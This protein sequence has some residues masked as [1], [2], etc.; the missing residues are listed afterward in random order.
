MGNNIF[1][2]LSDQIDIL[3]DSSSRMESSED[4]LSP[5]ISRRL[6]FVLFEEIVEDSPIQSREFIFD[7][8]VCSEDKEL[9]DSISSHGITTPIIIRERPDGKRSRDI[10][11]GQNPGERKFALVAGHRRVAAGKAAGLSGA[12]GVILNPGDDPDLITLAEN[13]GRK[14]LSTYEKG[15]ALR[16]LQERQGLSGRQVSEAVGLSRTHTNRLLNA[17]EAPEPLQKL[18]KEGRLSATALVNL[19]DHWTEISDHISEENSGD[20]QSLSQNEI[21]DLSDQLS[22]GASI[23]QALDIISAIKGNPRPPQAVSHP[24]EKIKSSPDEKQEASNEKNSFRSISKEG[25]IQAV[26]EVF[27]RIR[28]EKATALYDLSIASGLKDL[29]VFW[30]AALYVS[31][32]G[33][34]N[35]ALPSC[36]YAMKNRIFRALVKREIKNMKQ[37][38]AVFKTKKQDKKIKQVIRT[39]FPGI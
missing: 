38:A 20:F 6:T 16:S 34:L 15:L 2:D 9:L 26:R 24:T 36:K 35:E 22:A 39:C 5:N 13:Q 25:L 29:D 3:T 17:L 37:A 28:Q 14:E 19:K 11:L 10:I 30:A 21:Q 27:P 31:R 32:R 33:D 12:H 18:W 1:T 7:P 8:E 23:D 4:F